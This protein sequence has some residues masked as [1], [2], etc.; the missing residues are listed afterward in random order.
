[1]FSNLPDRWK[2]IL[3]LILVA[4]LIVA[5]SLVVGYLIKVNPIPTSRS[6]RLRVETSGGYSIIT[7]QAGDLK[8]DK[9][10]TV[11]TPWQQ[12]VEVKSGEEVYLTA[13]NP[14]QTGNLTC[15]IFLDEQA[16]KKETTSAPKDGVA[17]AGIVP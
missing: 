4:V 3:Q 13:S 11:S 16:W 6:V 7:L 5:L 9:P 10:K 14:T 12:I 8:I 15:S 2:L 1:M 17:C